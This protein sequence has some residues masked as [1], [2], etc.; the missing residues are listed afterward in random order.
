MFKDWAQ[1]KA[2]YK[3]EQNCSI[4]QITNYENDLPYQHQIAIFGASEL[5]DV[6]VVIVQTGSLLVVAIVEELNVDFKG[7]MSCSCPSK[8]KSKNLSV[9]NATYLF[10]F[11]S[12]NA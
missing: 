4:T 10:P 8:Y 3:K 1:V 11:K 2:C 6:E 9:P 12:T 5:C 7:V